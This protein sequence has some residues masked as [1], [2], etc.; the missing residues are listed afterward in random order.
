MEHEEL[1]SKKQEQGTK[2][3]EQKASEEMRLTTHPKI[4][5][6]NAVGSQ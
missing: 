5:Q 4:A 2:Y 6:I 1:N 3:E